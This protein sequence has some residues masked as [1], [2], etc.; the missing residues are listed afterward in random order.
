MRA[1][2]VNV[3]KIRRST[4]GFDPARWAVAFIALLTMAACAS[5]P[6]PTE[7]P[8]AQSIAGLTPSGTVKLT[9]AFVGGAGVGKGVLTFKGKTYP[10][11]LLGSVIGPGSV[12]SRLS[13]SNVDLCREETLPRFA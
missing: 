8:T 7:V 6:I 4:R 5:S 11:R 10:F 3:D 12:S 1:A 2:R 13:R 9:E